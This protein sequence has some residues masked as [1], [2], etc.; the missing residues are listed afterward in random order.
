[1]DAS[2]GLSHCVSLLCLTAPY[3][4][5]ERRHCTTLYGQL[6]RP[7]CIQWTSQYRTGKYADININV[8]FSFVLCHKIRFRC[9][10]QGASLWVKN[11]FKNI[12][13][14]QLS[15]VVSSTLVIKHNIE[16]HLSFFLLRPG[17]FFSSFFSFSL[18]DGAM[19]KQ[20]IARC[21]SAPLHSHSHKAEK[22]WVKLLFPGL[23]YS[24][25]FTCLPTTAL[26]ARSLHA[27]EEVEG[28]FT[29]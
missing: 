10:Q 18:S 15:S 19:E 14:S 29:Q 17:L 11:S 24:S 5:P 9:H 23:I 1:M 13:G 16:H 7:H 25:L 28:E 12:N 8:T 26:A 22:K 21:C 6:T 4:K 20:R 3:R 2:P 27:R